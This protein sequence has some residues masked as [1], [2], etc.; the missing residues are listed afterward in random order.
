MATVISLIILVIVVALVVWQSVK[1][2]TIARKNEEIS[3]QQAELAAFEKMQAQFPQLMD[4]LRQQM[5]SM[6]QQVTNEIGGF[7]GELGKGIEMFTGVQKIIGDV[8]E[9]LGHLSEMSSSIS[10][11]ERVL[12]PPQARGGVGETLLE[13]ALAQVLRSEKY[14]KCQYT[15]YGSERVD[16][17]VFIGDRLVPIDAKFPIEPFTA[18]LD[19]KT[20]EE[21]K[22]VRAQFLSMVRDKMQDIAAKYIRP[23]MGTFDFALMYVPSENVY[24]EIIRHEPDDKIDIFNITAGCKVI[25]V[26]PNTLY[27][28]LQVIVTGLKGMEIEKRAASIYGDLSA[29]SEELNRFEEDFMKIGAHIKNA[30]DRFQDASRTLTRLN[31]HLQTFTRPEDELVTKERQKLP[32]G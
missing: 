20:E 3:R 18:I 15:L 22:K 7:R 12:R 21:K 17:V 1:L 13:N 14:Y 4:A 2:S 25:P 28:Y 16:A 19:A 27:A 9:H 32:G 23:E 10:G 31:D 24:Y 30:Q 6:R 11:L 5:D 26:S 8:R 29:L